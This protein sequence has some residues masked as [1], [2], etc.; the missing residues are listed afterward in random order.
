MKVLCVFGKY[1]Y[2]DKSRGIATEYAA[3]IPALEKLGHEVIHFESWDMS[4]YGDYANLNKALLKKAID[5]HPDVLL[6]VQLHYEIWIETIE[7][8]TEMGSIATISWTSDD[9]W[10]YKEVSR[11][12]GTAYTA[13]TTTYPD[14]V[15]LYH[16]DG[17]PN[18]LLTQWGASSETFSSP[19]N[20]SQCIYQVSFVGRAFG[21]RISRV[22]EIKDKGIEVQCFG[23]GWDSGSVTDNEMYR[24]MKESF[25]SINFANSRGGN[26][27]KARTFEIP[28]AGG[29]LL[30]EYTPGLELF[31]EIG[32]EIDVFHNNEELIEKIN[33]YLEQ[34]DL[35][36]SIALN[37]F[38]RT[39]RDH[40]YEKRVQEILNFAVESK[41]ITTKEQNSLL[42]QDKEKIESD[43]NKL[44]EHTKIT[45]NMLL[46]KYLLLN[47]CLIIWGNKKGPK[48]ARRIAYEISLR[49][50]GRKT[51]TSIKIGRAHV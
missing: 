38:E 22:K 26:Q 21:S 27:I 49:T 3:F 2:G 43:F 40:C 13:M 35:R 34:P 29:F 10:K 20:A 14:I 11:F 36:D 32:K 44:C 41:K 16:R 31:Y 39:S 8:I 19:I 37:G 42:S 18:V 4:L 51:F 15:S 7:I 9:S 47:F 17:I 30:T 33:F 24:I 1:Q 5:I 12:I 25:I 6:T 28:G 48:A 23:H 46:L 45:K 50:W